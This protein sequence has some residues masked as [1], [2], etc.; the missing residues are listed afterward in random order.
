MGGVF[1]NTRNRGISAYIHY[2]C[3]I[4]NSKAFI[5]DVLWLCKAMDV[6]IEYLNHAVK[7]CSMVFR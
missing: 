1:E 2:F 5:K 7:D 3:T 4:G 6:S